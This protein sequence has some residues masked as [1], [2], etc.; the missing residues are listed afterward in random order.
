MID[1]IGA[2]VGGL[3]SGGSCA[4][5][6]C[7]FSLTIWRATYLSMPQSNSTHTI[8]MPIPDDERTRRTP[9][10]PLTADSIGTVT[11]VSTSW[12]ARPCASVTTVTDGAVR[13]GNTSTGMRKVAT[14]P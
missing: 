11:R 5:T 3:M 14:V 13:S 12:G 2:S 4:E 10:A 8:E 7:S 1:E 9:V 6:I